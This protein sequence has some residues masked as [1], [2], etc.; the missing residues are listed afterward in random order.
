[1]YFTYY[2]KPNYLTSHL[3]SVLHY[4]RTYPFL[5][6]TIKNYCMTQG[7]FDTKSRYKKIHKS[8]INEW[9]NWLRDHYQYKLSQTK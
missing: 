2:H 1:M 8:E 5:R 6:D 4:D 3:R 7:I 9:K